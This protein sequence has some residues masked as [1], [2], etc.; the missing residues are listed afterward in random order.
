MI[1]KH[2]V[3][4]RF[5]REKFDAEGR[6]A[7]RSPTNP[8]H[9]IVLT[10][11]TDSAWRVTSLDGKTPT[12]HRDYDH[13]DGGPPTNSALAEFAD[14]KLILIPLPKRYRDRR[15]KE[16]ED[17]FAACADAI[18]RAPDDS[19]RAMPKQDRPSPSLNISCTQRSSSSKNSSRPLRTSTSREIEL[20]SNGLADPVSVKVV[21]A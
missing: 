20:P 13:L 11:G 10:R 2:R 5:L 8:A 9:S 15:I 14:T 3:R 19:A 7:A 1:D 18:S 17:G 12:G 4:M 6:L 21:A 16:A